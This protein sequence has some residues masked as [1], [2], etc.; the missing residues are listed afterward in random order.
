MKRKAFTLIELLV[1]IAIIAILAAIL[2]PVFARARENARRS[3]CASNLKQIGLGI[4]QYMQDSDGI[5]PVQLETNPTVYWQYNVAPYLK[6]TQIYSCPS[7]PST[8]VFSGNSQFVAYGIN[9]W[10]DYLGGYPIPATESTIS[11]PSGTILLCDTTGW[12]GSPI[13]ERGYYRAYPS[14]YGGFNNRNSTVYGFDYATPQ[15]RV[16]DRH[17]DGTNILWCDG[18]V[19]WMKRDILDADTGV[20]AASKY[21]YGR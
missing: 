3:S 11:N 5:Y 18:H 9:Y 15:T 13:V 20:Y 7:A 8:I 17:F 21:W 19:K 16:S 1:V 2:F 14:Y 4:M 6:S 10:L 12:A